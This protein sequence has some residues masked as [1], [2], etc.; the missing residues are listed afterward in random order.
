MQIYRLIRVSLSIQIS[1]LHVRDLLLSFYKRISRTYAIRERRDACAS[2]RKA[3]C[4]SY[5][6]LSLSDVTATRTAGFDGISVKER[7]GKDRVELDR[8]KRSRERGISGHSGAPHYHIDRY[9]RRR[10]YEKPCVKMF[11][12]PLL[13]AIRSRRW[14][15]HH[16]FTSNV[17]RSVVQSFGNIGSRGINRREI[18]VDRRRISP[19]ID[20][21]DRC[22]LWWHFIILFQEYIHI[23][24]GHADILYLF[25]FLYCRIVKRKLSTHP[26][27]VVLYYCDI[28]RRE[29]AE[30]EGRLR[31]YIPRGRDELVN[32]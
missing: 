31:G 32:S 8:W 13:A 27:I 26:K 9:Y 11:S 25:S 30:S 10:A 23:S 18:T 29:F 12:T 17:S 21:I 19:L 28:L 3:S 6:F 2:C 5:N 20:Y 14:K 16:G 15:A 24:A 4:I 1:R 22:V 7:G